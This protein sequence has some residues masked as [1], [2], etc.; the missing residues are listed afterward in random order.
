MPT[1]PVCG[2]AAAVSISGGPKRA[3]YY[4]NLSLI[5]PLLRL[6]GDGK[7]PYLADFRD[8]IDKA[9]KGAAGEAYRDLVRPKASMSVADA[10]WTVM[11]EAYLKASDNGTLPA[12]ARQI[13]YA[14][15]GRI[16]E[17]TGLKKFSDKYFTQTLLPD[18]MQ[19]NAEETVDWDVIYDAR[20]HLT[21]PHTGEQVALGTIQVRQYVGQR[22]RRHSR[23]ALADG[24]LYPTTGP[25]HRYRNILFVEKEGFDELFEA[26]QLAERYDLAIMSTKGMSVVAA[27]ALLD[28]MAPLVDH[29][30]VLHD[31]DVSGFSIFGT[32]G[33]D[34]RRYTFTNDVEAKIVDIGL[35]LADVEAVDLEA[36]IVDVKSREARRMTLY[37]HGAS[38]AEVQ[39]LAPISENEDCR[40]VE[41]NA[42][43]SRQLVDFVEAALAANGVEKV[44]P[45]SEVLEQQARH[46]LQVM[47]TNKRL[48]EQADEIAQQAAAMPLPEG[49][50]AQIRELLDRQPELSWDQALAQLI[51]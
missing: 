25:Q 21:E 24:V 40:R 19:L 49:L 3:N 43:T 42:M 5:A 11:E 32:L 10:A 1:A 47:L 44:M 20:G 9:V 35:R 26:V 37:K 13:M 51:G 36:E 8:A 22:P 4:I 34:S 17:L 7:A 27:R 29:I 23:P 12:K 31:F 45:T 48:A 41:L 16:L 39:F 28:E 2:S 15:R 46:R 50:T 33:T 14:A 18:Y 30:F 6:T 38:Y